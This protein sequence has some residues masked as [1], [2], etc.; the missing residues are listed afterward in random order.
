[1]RIYSLSDLAATEAL[2]A[3][4]GPLVR[5]GDLLAL[6]GPLGAGKTAFARAFLRVLGVEDDVPSPTF[7]LVQGYDLPRFSIY[8]Y[9]LY[10]L[11]SP[12]ELVE[13]GWD[14]GLLEGLTLVEWP[15]RASG[16]MPTDYLLLR[17]TMD[18][19]E[20]RHCAVEP[21]GDWSK[22]LRGFQ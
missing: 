6:Q 19:N 8:H 2:A 9:D 7:T 22:R 14:E 16:H 20:R 11:K 4:L 1:M 5:K 21:H 10:R 17:F 15:E 18:D 13:L 3:R 12:D